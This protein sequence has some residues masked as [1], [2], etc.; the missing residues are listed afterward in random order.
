MH[1]SF[2]V[3]SL[4]KG[5]FCCVWVCVYMYTHA[6]W[7][8]LYWVINHV[9]QDSP[10]CMYLTWHILGL[11]LKVRVWITKGLVLCANQKGVFL[12]VGRCNSD[13][14]T[15]L[16]K[17]STGLISAPALSSRPVPYALHNWLRCPFFSLPIPTCP[18]THFWGS[19]L[20]IVLKLRFVTMS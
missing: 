9:T 14:D 20:R 10:L 18:N 2:F 13:K 19:L 5:L 3:I 17:Y 6:S 4:N 15:W 1:S 12:P 11:E 8:K 16:G 7:S